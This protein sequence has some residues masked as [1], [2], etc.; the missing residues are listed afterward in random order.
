MCRT[1]RLPIEQVT[2]FCRWY[3]EQ[4]ATA[5]G[6]DIQLLGIGRTG[7]IG[8]N[9]PGSGKE[10]R[11]RLITL[12]RV[13]RIDAASDFFGQEHVPRRAITMGVGTIL[14][15]RQ[16]IMLAF[17]EHKAADHRR[18]RSKGEVSA[19]DRRQLPAGAS[20]RPGRAR[21][22]GRRRA[23]ALQDRRGCSGPVEWDERKVRKAVIW[24]A[25]KLDKPILK[26]TDEDYNEEGLQDLLADRGPAYDIN[27]KVFRAPAGDDHRLAR[28]QAGPRA[29]SRATVR[30]RTTTFSRSACSCSRR[31]RTTT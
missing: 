6:I 2:D 4:I 31:I 29:S 23:H 5:G 16:V 12:D 9:E 21:R 11:T 13:T 22:G 17:G 26:L 15:A 24:L 20:E 1:A 14:D 30:S 28:R 8:F 27:I 3:E 19:V 25:R 18:R 10:S 7:H